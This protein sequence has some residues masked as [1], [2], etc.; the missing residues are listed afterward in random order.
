MTLFRSLGYSAMA[1]CCGGGGL[2]AIAI[3][4]GYYRYETGIMIVTVILLIVLF[5]IFQ[6]VGMHVASKL[7]KRK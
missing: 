6:S 3:Q 7:D 5:Q 1:G 2:G 4:Y